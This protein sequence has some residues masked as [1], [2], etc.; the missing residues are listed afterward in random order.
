MDNFHKPNDSEHNICCFAYLVTQFLDC[1]LVQ[2]SVL[3][4]I[5]YADHTSQKIGHNSILVYEHSE[6]V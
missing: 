4:M 5:C 2:T 1:E 3:C 6:S